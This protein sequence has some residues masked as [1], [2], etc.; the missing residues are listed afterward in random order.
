[1]LLCAVSM[2]FLLQSKALCPSAQQQQAEKVLL[3]TLLVALVVP[4]VAGQRVWAR[5][6]PGFAG[7]PSG[8]G[9]TRSSLAEGAGRLGSRAP[10]Y[11][12]WHSR[13]VCTLWSPGAPTRPPI[14][15]CTQSVVPRWSLKQ[16]LRRFGFCTAVTYH[17]STVCAWNAGP[18][19]CNAILAP[20]V[21]RSCVLEDCYIVEAQGAFNA[22][23]VEE[24]EVTW[25]CGDLCAKSSVSY[26]PALFA[27]QPLLHLYQ[28]EASTSPT[29]HVLC[30]G[31]KGE[32][33]GQKGAN[34]S[35]RRDNHCQRKGT[36]RSTESVSKY[37]QSKGRAM[38]KKETL[39]E[40]KK[41]NH[42][43]KRGSQ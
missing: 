16:S 25:V 34:H 21:V 31:Q 5:R 23:R 35:K 40:K 7:V 8:G 20:W 4:V 39:S 36:P 43:Q 24:G 3:L 22:L 27:G 37:P 33:H 6:S 9:C 11:C 13:R 2:V 19:D 41:D 12:D 29:N 10:S 17:L 18:R 32:S 42:C 14:V 30:H 1:M 38:A 15:I 28:V 26:L